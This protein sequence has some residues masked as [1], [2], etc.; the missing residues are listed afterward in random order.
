MNKAALLLGEHINRKNVEI[1]GNDINSYLL[2]HLQNLA[3]SMNSL[4]GK[5]YLMKSEVDALTNCVNIL[6]LAKTTFKENAFRD[7]SST[8]YD[9][10]SK[11]SDEFVEKIISHIEKLKTS[12]DDFLK[13]EVSQ[14]F[15]EMEIYFDTLQ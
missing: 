9:D 6:N 4:F 10:V 7:N 15:S 14:S 5:N 13:Q 1:V 12:I 11:I 2:N 3:I 8:L